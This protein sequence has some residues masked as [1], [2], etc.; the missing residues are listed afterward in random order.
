M[1]V[2]L[3]A[4]HEQLRQLTRTDPDPR[5]RRRAHALLLVGE[6]HSIAA[7]AR[8]FG[9]APHRVRAWRTRFLAG[10][11]PSLA[12]E[13][14]AGRPPK[15]DATAR[16]FLEEALEAGLQ[17][18]GLP[19]T[20]WSIRDLREVLVHRLGV[21]VCTATVHH[22]VQRLGFR[23]R[24][25]RHDLTHRQDHKAVAAT[26]VPA[27]DRGGWGGS[28][29]RC[30]RGAGLRLGS[31]RVARERAQG[32]E[33]LRGF[34]RSP[35]GHPPGWTDGHRVGQCGL[36]QESAGEDLVDDAPRP[37]A[38]VVAA[39]L[40]TRV[41]L[42]GARLELRQRQAQLPSLVGRSA[43]LGTGHGHLAGPPLRTVPS[44]RSGRYRSHPDL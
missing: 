7:V 35:G 21:H 37:G 31:D 1:S 14:R 42:E 15:L 4:Q 39:S 28:E 30:L 18:Y 16:A 12:D 13:P 29:V 22:A 3:S 17:A 43:R 26:R 19:V 38:S 11:H 25:P 44:A 27:E 20:I 24:R 40:R 8:L 32:R 23:Y 2:D 34:P 10:G 5:V 41:E 36:P 9:T 33:G 6:G